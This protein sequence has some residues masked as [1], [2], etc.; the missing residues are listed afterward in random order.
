MVAGFC[1][2]GLWEGGLEDAVDGGWEGGD[3]GEEGQV[4]INVRDVCWDGETEIRGDVCD[5]RSGES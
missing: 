1:G 3:I 5:L 4:G 2:F